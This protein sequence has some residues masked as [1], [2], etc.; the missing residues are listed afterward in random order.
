MYVKISLQPRKVGSMVVVQYKENK[1][2]LVTPIKIKKSINQICW[3]L[4]YW[5]C[6]RSNLQNK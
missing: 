5:M 3:S 2:E 6:L 1:V 4:I